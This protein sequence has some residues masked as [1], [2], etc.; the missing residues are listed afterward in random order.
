MVLKLD[1][2]VGD[3]YKTPID[4]EVSRSKVTVTFIITLGSTVLRLD[5]EVGSDSNKT[6]ID[7]EVS[8]SKVTVTFIIMLG[9]TVL[10][11]DMDVGTRTRPF[12]ILRSVGQRS[13]SQ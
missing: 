2:K 12:L 11:F 6:P 10:R 1:M 5:V 4:F 7:F 9:S 3:S 8:R 13:R